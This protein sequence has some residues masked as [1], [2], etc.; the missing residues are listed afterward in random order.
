MDTMNVIINI[1][2]YHSLH[3][4]DIHRLSKWIGIERHRGI[5]GISM[6]DG[7]INRHRE[8]KHES[9]FPVCY[10]MWKA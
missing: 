1:G 2:L 3:L 10:G 8:Q 7:R 4:G 6:D 5:F 9:S